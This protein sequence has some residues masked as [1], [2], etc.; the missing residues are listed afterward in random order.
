MLEPGD[1]AAVAA[2]F[3]LGDDAALSGPVARGEV[4]Q[5]WRLSTSLGTFAVKEPFEPVAPE[6][7]REHAAFQEAAH[8][9]GIP[10]PSVIRSE[11]GRVLVQMRDTRVRVF[12]WVDLLEHDP[13]VDP[14]EV[15]T[16]LA[17]IHRL[18]FAGQLP[19][20]PWYTEPVGAAR[21]DAL[22]R[23]LHAKGAPFTDG[24]AGMRDSLVSVEELVEP[25]RELQTCHR[26]LWA[27]N[28]LRMTGGGLCVIDW[29]NCGM[30]DPSHELAVVLFEF[31]RGDDDRA[32]TLYRAY[33]DGGGPGRIDR[34]G[35]FS[36]LIAQLGHIGED[37][38]RRWLDPLEPV[39]ERERQVARAQ[40]FIEAPLT[41]SAIEALLDAATA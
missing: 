28:V 26:D 11:D 39:A 36:M 16:I 4:G 30:A 23:D 40:E 2:R 18:S 32:R 20:D 1:A 29:E 7:V 34:P 17:S 35:V 5:V 14:A 3:T 22:V 19:T 38:C 15:G 12:G 10:V 13:S 24:L 21:W 25:P 9:A 8:A 37:A 27:D 6:E 41:R 31:G 33:I